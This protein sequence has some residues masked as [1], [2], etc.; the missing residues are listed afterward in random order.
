MMQNN[1]D[2]T[3]PIF[4]FGGGSQ[5]LRR[6]CEELVNICRIHISLGISVTLLSGVG[7]NFHEDVSYDV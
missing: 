7:D 4:F 5:I 1:I 2:P 3:L 6:N